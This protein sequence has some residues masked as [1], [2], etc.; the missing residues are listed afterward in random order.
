MR[1]DLLEVLAHLPAGKASLQTGQDHLEVPARLPAGRL[2]LRASLDRLH[3]GEDLL[4]D[5]AHEEV[6][7][8][9]NPPAKLSSLKKIMYVS[10][11]LED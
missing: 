3:I 11:L 7:D 2:G 4:I 1:Q 6:P 10:F 5:R 9:I 8:L